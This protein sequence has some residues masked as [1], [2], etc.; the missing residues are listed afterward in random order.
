MKIGLQ[1]TQ[2]SQTK[3]GRQNVN[4]SRSNYGKMCNCVQGFF[5]SCFVNH[6]S[7]LFSSI[8]VCVQVRLS[9]PYRKCCADHAQFEV[10]CTSCPK[11][12]TLGNFDKFDS[13]Q[14]LVEPS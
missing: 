12:Q 3:Q 6:I 1:R 7:V 11:A 13:G 4:R 9:Y 5:Q 10:P 2:L 14:A 8:F